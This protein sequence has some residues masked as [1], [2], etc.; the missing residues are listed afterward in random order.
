[1]AR[2]A[3]LGSGAVGLFYGSQLVQAGHEVRFWLRR[4]LARIRQDGITVHSHGS[5]DVAGLVAPGLHLPA[6]RFAACASV[7]ECLHGAALDWVLIAVKTT[8]LADILPALAQ[9]CADARTRVVAMCN[10]IGIE[11]LLAPTVGAHRLFAALA[12]VCLERRADG[13]V[14]H[15]AHGKLLL[16]QARDERGRCGSSQSWSR[17]PA[18]PATRSARCARHAGAN[19]YG[20]CPTTD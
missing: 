11:E 5:A 17:A 16:G 12:H 9:L 15:Q 6:G 20:T 1:M 8:Q 7:A 4:D 10:G 18:S 14:E 13:S 2:V 19:W 3:V